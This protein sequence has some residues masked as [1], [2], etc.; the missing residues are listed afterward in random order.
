MAL[1]FEPAEYKA[2]VKAVIKALNKQGLDGLLMF[3]QESMY[4]LTGYDTFGFCFFQCLYLGTDG[5]IALLTRTPD[6]RQAR[7]TSN[8]EDI[9]V[10]IDREGAEPA[11]DLKDMLQSLGAKG[12][13]LG[14]ENNAY[15]LTHAN[16]KA[17]VWA[18]ELSRDRVTLRLARIVACP[19]DLSADGQVDGADLGALL[20]QWGGCTGCSAD[21]NQD[22]IVNGAD[23]GTL[24]AAWGGCL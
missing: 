9:R 13:K 2:R 11:R 4:Y 18:V 3:N 7:H 23:L 6:L 20:A 22:G 8:I 5:K 15:G 10:W 24:L 1:H 12:K 21:F 16:G 14:I 19:A 17:Y